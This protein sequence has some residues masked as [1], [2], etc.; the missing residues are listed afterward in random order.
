MVICSPCGNPWFGAT[1]LTVT[2][3]VDVQFP[4]ASMTHRL[5]TGTEFSGISYTSILIGGRLT[6]DVTKAVLVTVVEGAPTPSTDVTSGVPRL[7]ERRSAAVRLIDD[8]E[9]IKRVVSREVL[10]EHRHA[11]WRAADAECQHGS[12]V[13][14]GPNQASPRPQDAVRILI[15]HSSEVG[16]ARRPRLCRVVDA[17]SARAIRWQGG[18]CPGPRHLN[19]VEA[20]DLR[21]VQPDVPI[22]RPRGPRGRIAQLTCIRLPTSQAVRAGRPGFALKRPR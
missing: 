15:P 6:L 14:G 13:A 12:V 9:F 21:T 17:R 7:I 16:D 8:V 20:V 10:R 3:A 4:C 5:D 18:R 1:P 19:A 11:T 2:P 22:V